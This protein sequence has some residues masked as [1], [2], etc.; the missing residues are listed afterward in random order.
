MQCDIP[1]QGGSEYNIN[2]EN[3]FYDR[4]GPRFSDNEKVRG[5]LVMFLKDVNSL[6]ESYRI[7]LGSELI[8]Q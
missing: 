8:L 2:Y 7:L 1:D 4:A 6:F 3:N 5:G